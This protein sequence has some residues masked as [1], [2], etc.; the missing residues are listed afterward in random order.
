MSCVL[1]VAA[2]ALS[3]CQSAPA[4]Q[5]VGGATPTGATLADPQAI[6]EPTATAMLM[7]EP[8]P[9]A[10]GEMIAVP[11]SLSPTAI[12]R[13]SSS[14]ATSSLEPTRA[15]LPD[16]GDISAWQASTATLEGVSYSYRYPPEWTASL[17]YCAPGS[18][19][20]GEEGGHLPAGCVSTDFLVGQKALDMGQLRGETLT[21]NGKQA[22]K[23]LET[24]PASALVSRIYTVMVYGADG[25]PVFGFSSMIGAST[26]LPT[27]E[28]ITATL[29]KIASTVQ[30]NR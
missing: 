27:Q 24:H 1:L 20:A 25:A 10:G 23:Q 7:T 11:A 28:A 19:G 5:P 2:F 12:V 3:G 22:V 8:T 21:I 13:G 14:P 15:P 9:T 30:V 16:A 29:D 17:T 6:V 26:D 4:S 18:R